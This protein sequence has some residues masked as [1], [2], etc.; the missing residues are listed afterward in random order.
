MALTKV[1]GN[2][3]Q[4]TKADVGLAN[5][6][7]TADADKPIPSSV[8]DALALK[9][10]LASPTFTGTVGGIDKT[11]V[12]LG[13]VDNTADSAKPVSTL[14]QTALDLKANLASPALTGT[15]TAPTAAAAT[16]TTQIANTA[17][18]QQEIASVTGG[19]VTG[20]GTST[21]NGVVGFNGTGGTVLK[22][23][24]AAQVRDA[25]DLDTTDS[26]QFTA[27][28]LGHATDTTIAR[29][30]AGVISVE[31]SNVL[32]A[33]GLGSVTQAYDATLAALAAFNTNGSLHQTATDTFVARTLTGTASQITVTNG[34][35]VSGNPT[36]SLPADVL[37]PTVLTV[38]N[39]GLHILDTNASHDLIIAP[40][41][42]L[43]ADRTLTVTTGDNDRT[44]DISGAS[45][46]VS[47]FAATFLDDADAAAVKTTLGIVAGGAVDYIGVVN[48]SASSSI[49]FIG[50]ST[51]YDEFVI[52]L[53]DVYA[54]AA[55][56]NQPLNMTVSTNNGSSY[57]ALAYYSVYQVT[58]E[59]DSSSS[60][61][62][63]FRLSP[64]IN[65]ADNT[66]LFGEIRIFTGDANAFRFIS[67]IVHQAGNSYEVAFGGGVLALSGTKVNAIKFILGTTTVT[68]NV[69]LYGIKNS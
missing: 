14:Q 9:A 33:S 52:V 2:M 12:G 54:A 5:V 28:N 15:P 8:T 64:N 4:L 21:D 46:T 55:V 61:A 39:T 38:P 66:G 42:N 34:D 69:K 7:N 23:L 44:L 65:N 63:N 31:G 22:E 29:V 3:T 27:I 67:H 10:P 41:S 11:M 51:S 48:A 16:N 24:T 62:V 18:V 6:N 25:A 19:S 43:T 59:S 53:Q 17:F 30:S 32:L 35:G 47:A 45:V 68:G 60:N 49:E 50:L 26:P 20:P 13:S 58:G 1:P 40:G 57:I 37:I 36:V 56:N